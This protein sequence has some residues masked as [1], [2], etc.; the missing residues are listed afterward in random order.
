[1]GC[2]IGGS[3]SSLQSCLLRRRISGTVRFSLRPEARESSHQVIHL[4]WARFIEFHIDTNLVDCARKCSNQTRRGLR[5]ATPLLIQRRSGGAQPCTKGVPAARA[6]R[7]SKSYRFDLCPW[8]ST[9]EKMCG[10]VSP[11]K[12]SR[13]LN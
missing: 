12:P 3:A 13:S 4:T 1:M 8:E 10:R 7:Q 6:E 5:A 2:G 11:V 9:P